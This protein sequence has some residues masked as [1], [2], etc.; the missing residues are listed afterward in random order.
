MAT[1]EAHAPH[2]WRSATRHSAGH[3]SARETRAQRQAA[4]D[5]RL[6]LEE[7]Y[8]SPA[9]YV[10]AVRAAAD[11]MVAERLL[12]PDVDALNG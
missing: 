1:P 6:S 3:A 12:L 11:A 7:R 5:P 8:A 4:G 2:R 10:A 9:A